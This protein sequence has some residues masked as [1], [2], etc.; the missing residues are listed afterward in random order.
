MNI[1]TFP[2]IKIRFID[3]LL[4]ASL[5]AAAA[6]ALGASPILIFILACIGLI[7]L[8]GQMGNATEILAA[9]DRSAGGRAA[10]RDPRKRRRTDHHP[11]GHPGG[12]PRI[13]EGIDHGFDHREPA[14]GPGGQPAG[15]RD[16]ERHAAF[17]QRHGQPVRH[18]PGAGGG[19][20]ERA[21]A[22]RPER[23]F[24]GQHPCGISQPGRGGRDD[25][26]LHPQPGL[27]PER[28]ERGDPAA[29][30]RTR[31]PRRARGKARSSGWGSPRPEW[32][33]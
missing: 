30:R 12:L 8:A 20:P 13:G 26:D 10:Q 32:S 5:L 24:A 17:L 22:V 15:G 31:S 4:L 1:K 27:F 21:V 9:R 2:K 25:A 33:S 28:E 7:P 18:A 23:R 29:G 3:A 14:P 6:W 19:G 16:Q 11:G